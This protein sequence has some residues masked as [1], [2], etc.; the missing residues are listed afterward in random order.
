MARIK[1]VLRERQRLHLQANKLVE[2]RD[3]P[4]KRPEASEVLLDMDRKERL[5][6]VKRKRQF[7]KKARY[8]NRIHPHF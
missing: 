5:R 1:T 2:L 4:G 7:R 3:N 6:L 8:Q